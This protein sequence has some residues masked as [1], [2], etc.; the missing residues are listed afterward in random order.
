MGPQSTIV[1]L[2]ATIEINNSPTGNEPVKEDISVK[3]VSGANV[4]LVSKNDGNPSDGITLRFSI[5]QG[6]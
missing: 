4:N 1:K 6:N 3:S 2:V 5:P